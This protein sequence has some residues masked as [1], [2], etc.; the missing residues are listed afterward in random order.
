M[1]L[2]KNIAVLGA[3]SWG[4]ALAMVLAHNGHSVQLWDHN[5]VMMI[6]L[7]KTGSNQRYLPDI[8]FPK[9]IKV[10]LSLADALRN[11]SESL[12][13]VPSHGFKALLGAMKPLIVGTPEYGIVWATKGLEPETGAFL[14]TVVAEVLGSQRPMAVL[15]GPSFAKEVALRLPTAVMLASD[16]RA[17]LEVLSDYFTND[18]FAIETTNDMIGVQLSSVVKNILAVAVGLS[19]GLGFGANSAAVLITRGL[20]EMMVLGEALHAKRET[21][22]GLAGCGDTIL[23]CTDNQS[24]NRRLGLALAKGLTLEEAALQIGQSVESIHNVVQIMYLARKH[25]VF[26]PIIE[27]VYRIMKEGAAPKDALLSLFNRSS[28]GE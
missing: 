5:H 3:G 20:A 24:R 12:I 26:M 23:T 8:A 10:C 19:E 27:Q 4:T 17:F 22:M 1:T 15:S 9:A 16:D 2:Q 21:F 18:S 13:V 14:H 11:T 6:E 25:H 28:R 7:Q